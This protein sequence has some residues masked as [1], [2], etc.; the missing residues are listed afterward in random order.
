[1]NLKISGINFAIFLKDLALVMIFITIEST[2]LFL[3]KSDLFFFNVTQC[4]FKD[5]L[6][7]GPCFTE[8]SKT[9]HYRFTA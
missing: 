1:M 8:M 7:E 9:L 4:F 6:L 2:T 3:S 5:P